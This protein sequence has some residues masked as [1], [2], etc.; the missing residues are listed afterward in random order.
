M[1]APLIAIV[2]LAFVAA[3][4]LSYVQRFPF[5]RTVQISQ[6]VKLDVATVRGKIDIRAGAPGRVV[7]ENDATVRVGYD[8]P[9]NGH[10]RESLGLASSQC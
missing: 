6:A 8:V 2:V 3:P 4:S 10:S 7:V 5:E 1:R 9:A